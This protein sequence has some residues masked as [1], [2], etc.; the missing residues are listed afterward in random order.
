VEAI[1]HTLKKGSGRG[2]TATAG[3]T[4]ALLTVTA[5]VVSESKKAQDK[6]NSNIEHTCMHKRMKIKGYIPANPVV[7]GGVNA[8]IFLPLNVRLCFVVM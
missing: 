6:S 3:G 1:S 8:I 7:S 5:V 4:P 2:Q